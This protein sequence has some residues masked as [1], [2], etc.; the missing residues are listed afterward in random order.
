MQE[1][2]C[3][4]SKPTERGTGRRRSLPC[5]GS[6]SISA[7]CARSTTSHYL[8]AAAG[9]YSIIG[10][11]GAG[12]TSLVNMISGFY[13]PDTGSLVFEGKDI[14]DTRP[15]QI[16]ELGIARTFQNI[17]LFSRHDGARQHHAR[18]P[19]ADEG[20][21]VVVLHLLGPRAEGGSGA[22]RAGRGADRIP[23]TRGS[24]QAADERAGLRAAES[25]SNS[26]ARWRSTP[27][28]CCSTSRWAA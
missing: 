24:A 9:W 2:T 3:P 25:G 10:P 8:C 28:C 21:G 15:S 12:K 5:P 13:R 20:R 14:T 7:G 17:A 4:A 11:N 1:T 27:R 6:R 18:P 16:A 19:R 23:R 22:S 26:A